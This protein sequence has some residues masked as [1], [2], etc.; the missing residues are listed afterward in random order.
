[1]TTAA[2]MKL[3]DSV[4]FAAKKADKI[5]EVFRQSTFIVGEI[6]DSDDLYL[7]RELKVAKMPFAGV[8]V[9]MNPDLMHSAFDAL[10]NAGI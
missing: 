4:Y 6:Y 10:S 9:V 5:Q 3:V 7:P 2:A 8:L 1:L